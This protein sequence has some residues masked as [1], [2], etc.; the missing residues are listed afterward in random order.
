MDFASPSFRA[1]G[2]DL[3]VSISPLG[4]VELAD[5]EFEVHGPRLNRYA[6]NWATYLGHHYSYRAEA[7]EEQPVYNYY[8][9]FTDFLTRFTFGHGVQFSSPDKT[10]AIVPHLLK[11]VW[12]VDNDKM[13][14]LFEMGTSGA[15]SGDCFVKVAYEEPYTDPA[16]RVHPGRV[17]LLPLNS[18]YCL[19]VEDTEVLTRRGWITAD[20]LTTEDQVLSLD[21]ETDEMVWTEVKAVNIFDWDGPMH[22]WESERFSALSTPDHRWVHE[23]G[24]GKRS[25][26]TSSDLDQITSGGGSQ[27]VL[28]GGTLAHFPTEAKYTDDFVELVGW[29]VTEGSLKTGHRQG[30]GFAL[31]QSEDKNPEFVS[32]IRRLVKNFQDQG[33]HVSV[34]YLRDS[35]T[36]SWYFGASLG[37][38]VRAVLG[39][40]KAME[41]EFL[42]ALT[43]SQATLLYN[44]L[45]DGDGDTRRSRGE[46]F[47]Q[48]NWEVMDSFQML[49]MMLG[50]RSTGRMVE[51][52]Y[53]GTSKNSGTVSVYQN[54]THGLANLKREQVHYT[55]R[56]WC[57]TTGTGTW[58]ARRTV[59]NRKVTYL[60]GNCFPEYHPHDRS[61]LLRMKIKY[62]FWGTSPQGTRSVYTYVEVL[63]E[64]TITEYLNDEMIDQ[65]PN[66]L[67]VIPVVQIPNKPVPS[68]PWGLSDC[69]DIIQLNLQYNAINKDISDIVNYHSAPV[70]VIVGAKA[71]QLEKG[72]KKVWG[73]LP[74]EAQVFN[75]EGGG[76]GLKGALDY[77]EK[78]KRSMH[79]IVG[80]PETALG[81]VQPIS[82]TSGVALSIQFQ[83]LMNSWQ[84]KIAQYGDGLQKINELVLLTL[85]VKEPETL[86]WVPNDNVPLEEGQ[87]DVLDPADPTTYVTTVH[88]PPPLPLDKLVVLNEI[89][90]KMQMGLE[91]REGALRTLG[92]EYPKEKLSEISEEKMRDA[93]SDAAL[94]LLQTQLQKEIMDLTAMMPGMDGGPAT[95]L[96]PTMA[97]T[98]DGEYLGDGSNQPPMPPVDQ[99]KID[100][101]L[102]EEFLRNKLVTQAYGTKQVSSSEKPTDSRDA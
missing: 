80:I 67:G 6:I 8:R 3:T 90:M 40:N 82:N 53:Q 49:A 9:A 74:K 79:E 65:R 42:T 76:A 23:S 34:E 24:R 5:E 81:Q 96:D 45:L 55:G 78:I 38:E 31:T 1:A 100:L 16:G 61:R 75:L 83:P 25:I 59:G 51:R 11:R 39:T 21:P 12:E 46:F 36:V 2:Q 44:T 33:H 10:S 72:A 88:F 20:E 62:R 19:P 18:A 85:A 68:S 97:Q 64:S 29:V 66:P 30:A 73:G 15:V 98:S 57:P 69:Q 13:K 93:V 52:D 77:L 43:Y 63:T 101:F 37:H 70:T 99:A 71:S 47:W 4:L 86:R 95:P 22:S 58:V 94:T 14:V 7:G 32:R 91:S 35:G 26:R 56:V 17:R 48:N 28:A 27:L 89:Q 54:R 87:V 41:A 60:T 102:G 92:E 50:K 84:Q